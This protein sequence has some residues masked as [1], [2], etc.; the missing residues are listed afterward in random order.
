MRVPR[1]EN[2]KKMYILDKIAGKD[3]PA[4]QYSIQET[5]LPRPHR[6]TSI[7]LKKQLCREWLMASERE[8]DQQLT[9]WM[10]SKKYTDTS[11]SNTTRIAEHR[12]RWRTLTWATSAYVYA[13]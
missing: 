12:T 13:M 2:R 6:Q 9:G 4:S 5:K 1:T 11:I 8:A 10:T 7:P 3:D